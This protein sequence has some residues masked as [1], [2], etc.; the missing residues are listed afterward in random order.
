M[1]DELLR[2]DLK[3]YPFFIRRSRDYQ[4]PAQFLAR[5]CF[6]HS[7]G[8]NSL[9]W[10]LR[11][12]LFVRFRCQPS[13]VLQLPSWQGLRQHVS[14]KAQPLHYCQLYQVGA[15]VPRCCCVLLAMPW[16]HADC[17][18]SYLIHPPPLS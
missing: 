1:N 16:D 15:P 2:F 4:Q 14:V 8:G 18:Q 11:A 6:V 10:N 17:A 9:G 13:D 7:L 5:P 3:R 12:P